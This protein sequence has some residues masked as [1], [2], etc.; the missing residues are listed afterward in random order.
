M[1][2]KHNLFCLLLITLPLFCFAQENSPYSRYGVGNILPSG[3]I[4]NRGMGGISAGFS[5]A[6][7][8]NTVNP[9]TYGSL[10][11]TTLDVGI[12][13][14]GRTI[15]SQV[16]IG[17]YKSNNGIISYLQ[18]GFPLLNG[19]KKAMK[20]R[21]TWAMTFGLKPISRINYKISSSSEI[22]ADSATTTYEGNGG[23][24]EAL[25]GTALKIKNFSI[26][27]NT[28]YLFGSKDYSSRLGISNDSGDV[29]YTANYQTRTRFGGVFLNAGLQYAIKIKGG[30]LRLGAYGTMQQ[31]YNANKDDVRETISYD[32]STGSITKI[33]S[34]FQND[35]QKG[36]VQLPSTIGA[37]FTIEKA[38]ILFGAD[39][40]TT[41]WDSY[42]F[43]GQKD[44]VKNSWLGKFGIQYFPS[45]NGSSKYFDNV[46][47]RAGVSF[48]SDY[49]AV[50][51]NL[52]V[53]TISLGATLP[54]KLRHSFYDNQYSFMNFG[55]EYGKR[56]NKDNNI[57]ENIF[58]ISL[59]FSLS[60]VWFRRQKY[61]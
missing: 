42:R 33:D 6:G 2:P 49:I 40:E 32:A 30:F 46:R 19:N 5:D 12:E 34:V 21:T 16:P 8:I 41:N 23:I 26:G 37:G 52:P 53:Y 14:D 3:N 38:H 9:A 55:I 31:S 47:Y 29:F 59:G 27:F 48:G 56:G 61:Q 54:L 20:K 17:S 10:I 28:G 4:Q 13:Y 43:F 1:I 11:L 50:D 39:F 15:K 44:L 36:K 45:L 60:D 24:N 22:A 35:G 18:F 58:K 25:I 57:K 51:N 7:A